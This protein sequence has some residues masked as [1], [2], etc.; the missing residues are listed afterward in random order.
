MNS[1]KIAL[2]LTLLAG[3]L[4]AG[5]AQAGG[6]EV[7]WS[8]RL[9]TPTIRLPGHVVLPLPPIP[10]PR[11]VVVPPDRDDAHYQPRYGQ[12]YGRGHGHGRGYGWGYGDADRD[13]VPNRHDPV[14]N[15]RFDRDGDGVPNR[16]DARPDDPRVSRGWQEAR[17][18]AR[19]GRGDARDDRREDRRDDRRGDRRDERRDDRWGRHD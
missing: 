13:G 11:V 7:Q 8:L 16:Y 3:T 19:D 4:A 17:R 12:V 9:A 2:V 18:D 14:Y 10:V 6:P 5:A 15:P 1:R